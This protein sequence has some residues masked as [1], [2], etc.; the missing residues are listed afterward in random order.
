MHTVLHDWSRV[1]QDTHET[2]GMSPNDSGAVQVCAIIALSELLLKRR[3]TNQYFE[4]NVQ[5]RELSIRQKTGRRLQ[6][7]VRSG[8]TARGKGVCRRRSS[9]DVL[10]SI[11]VVEVAKR[12]LH[13]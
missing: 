9:G 11:E 7:N 8:C 6:K 4:E 3:A 1:Q 5:S 10:L 2:T 13:V 12:G